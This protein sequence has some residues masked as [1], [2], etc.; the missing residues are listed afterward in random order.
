MIDYEID[1]KP[2][3]DQGLSDSDIAQALAS[4][5]ANPMLCSEAR[6][7]LQEAGAVK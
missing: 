2:L 1:V 7:I 5:T 4:R 6:V 3:E